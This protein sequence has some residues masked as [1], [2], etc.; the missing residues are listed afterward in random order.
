MLILQSRKIQAM[1]ST[2]DSKSKI[3]F[4]V[5]LVALAAS[6]RLIQHPSNFTAIGA[7]AL[8]GGAVIRD[9]R[10]AFLLPFVAMLAT[11][12][13]LGFHASMIPVYA[14]FTFTVWLGT[15]IQQNRT[16]MKMATASLLS[17]IVFFLVTNLPFWYADI[18]LY[19]LTVQG[20]I[21]SYVAALPFFGNQLAGDLFF[22]AL[23]FGSYYVF[24]RQSSIVTD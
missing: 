16:V 24:S 23:L 17:S 22:T 3:I 13:I 1:S 7:M 21:E 19:P 12:A 15:K 5:L 10:L 2:L 14:C 9:R 20:M 8:F 6:T 18:S 4:P 11:D